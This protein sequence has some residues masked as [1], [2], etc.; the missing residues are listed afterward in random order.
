[1]D[2]EDYFELQKA[3]TENDRDKILEITKKARI[4][5]MENLSVVVKSVNK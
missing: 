5:I 1:M 2:I 3:I 4:K